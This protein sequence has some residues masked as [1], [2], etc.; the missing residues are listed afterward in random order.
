MVSLR[1]YQ[2][3]AIQS[4][5]ESIAKNEKS[6]LLYL[7]TGL[8][9]TV[10]ATG[11]A[12]EL[13]KKVLFIVH[14]EELAIQ[15]LKKFLIM[16]KTSQPGIVQGEHNQLGRKI[17]IA[18]IQTLCSEKRL[19]SLLEANQFDLVIVDEA[20]HYYTGKWSEIILTVLD[21]NPNAYLVGLTATPNRA[22]N[23]KADT[24]FSKILYRY[25][26]VNGIKNG[27]LCDITGIRYKLNADM[28][29][30]E[31]SNGDYNVSSLS[32]LMRTPEVIMETFNSWQKYAEGK[33]TIIFCVSLDHV[34]AVEDYFLYKNI[35]VESITGETKSEDRQRIYEDFEKGHIDILISCLV[36]TEGFDSPGVECVLLARPTISEAL[37]IQ[38]VGR[39]LRLYPNKEKC[40]V[41]DLVGNSSKH[42]LMQLGIL[43]GKDLQRE[44]KA[45]KVAKHYGIEPTE[46][47]DWETITSIAE[48][49]GKTENLN[50]QET[51]EKRQF[52][53]VETEHG[54]VLNLG[55]KV[56]FLLL[57]R[58]GYT[59][60]YRI[61][62]YY[63]KSWKDK[64]DIL[65][66]GLPL[67]WA[68]TIAEKEAIRFIGT[69]TKFIDKNTDWRNNPPSEK[70]LQII[71]MNNLKT[72]KTSGEASH[73]LGKH[74]AEQRIKGFMLASNSKQGLELL[75]KIENLLK[76]DKLTVKLG[77]KKL[78]NL[79][80]NEADRVLKF[81]NYNS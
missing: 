74:F 17:T 43:F 10:I 53:W 61:V 34:K 26:I 66:D 19:N 38:M 35:K 32:N 1:S 57:E 52:E 9:K 23:A 14:R 60:F 12:K 46:K 63:N 16:D 75:E 78:S 67:D 54:L 62:H 4:V 5:K 44:E 50:L 79:S 29:K 13:D 40:I 25:S 41:I 15:T 27:Y 3:E 59:S 37:Y 71:R 21:K 72:P 58:E 31:I 48:I 49:L 30:L 18:S 22:D 42:R 73:I 20:H 76:A 69:N 55:L 77:N 64:Q 11:L 28:D 33:R 68:I 7:A 2:Q 47:N 81:H 36:L 6:G 70:Q 24:I 56:G 65:V 80:F 51:E 8:G 45:E 39:G